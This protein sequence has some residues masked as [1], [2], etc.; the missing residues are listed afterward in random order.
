MKKYSEFETNVGD[1]GGVPE[2]HGLIFAVENTQQGEQ[3]GR[4]DLKTTHVTETFTCNNSACPGAFRTDSRQRT[5]APAARRPASECLWEHYHG[6]ARVDTEPA[7]E[8][9][10]RAACRAAGL[11]ATRLPFPQT[12]LHTRRTSDSRTRPTTAPSP[13]L[14]PPPPQETG[15]GRAQRAPARPPRPACTASAITRAACAKRCGRPGEARSG[16]P[17]PAAGGKRKGGGRR[18]GGR[19]TERERSVGGKSH[20]HRE[21]AHYGSRGGAAVG[22]MRGGL[23]GV[24]PRERAVQAHW[25][26]GGRCVLG[27]SV[28]RGRG[29]ACGSS[30]PH[31]K[32]RAM[33]APGRSFTTLWAGCSRVSP[34]SQ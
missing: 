5:R 4:P 19:S 11:A 28:G 34:L 2:R 16:P 24:P 26:R 17:S 20:T 9:P 33:N 3:Y 32:W 12:P 15:W 10:V 22:R 25:R 13:R 30:V 14:P 8:A 18:E 23:G 7:P 27:R 1:P 29:G 31:T 21:A 6:T